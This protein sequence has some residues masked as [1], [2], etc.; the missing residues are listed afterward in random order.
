MEN[1]KKRLGPLQQK[2]KATQAIEYVFE[3]L[4]NDTK[5][6]LRFKMKIHNRIQ[7]LNAFIFSIL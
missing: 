1:S 4:P 3:I 6:N 7:I 5:T 2:D